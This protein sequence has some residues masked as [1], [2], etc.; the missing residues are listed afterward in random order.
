MA[1]DKACTPA[2]SLA[3]RQ[4]RT[5]LSPLGV[6]D[7]FILESCLILLFVSIALTMNAMEQIAMEKRI[8]RKMGKSL[9]CGPKLTKAPPL[10][11]LVSRYCPPFPSI[12]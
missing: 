12:D 2:A 6:F 11:E 9:P 7:T 3:P 5:L 4:V 1:G 8:L 10:A